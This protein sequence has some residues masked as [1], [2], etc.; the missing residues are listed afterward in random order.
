MGVHCGSGMKRL[1]LLMI[2]CFC[3]IILF[4]TLFIQFLSAQSFDFPTKRCGISIGNSKRFTG[5]RVNFR[6]SRVDEIIG[7]NMTLWQPKDDNKDAI[8]KGIS[9]GLIPGGGQLNGIQF[10]LGVS[11]EKELKGISIGLLGIGSGENVIGLNIGGLGS[12]AGGNM[13]GFN[14]GLLGVGAGENLQG[15][16][17]GGLGCGAGENVCGFNIALLGLGAGERLSGI[18]LVGLGAGAGEKLEG[19]TIAGLGI[20]SPHIKGITVGGAGVGG[21]HIKGI[22]IALGTI[23]IEPGGTLNGFALSGFNYFRGGQVGVSVGLVNYTYTLKGLQLGIINIVR[24]NPR[25]LK[26]LPLVNANF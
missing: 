2:R 1:D 17:I 21:V 19:V 23:R 22:T 18:T 3:G 7:I 15:I 16:N 13:I 25:F 20:G 8:I 10:G 4:N 26:V 12:G 14:F 24:E 5:L 6:D 11:A 9:L